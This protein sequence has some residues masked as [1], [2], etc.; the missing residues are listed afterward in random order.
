MRFLLAQHVAK[1]SWTLFYSLSLPF[2]M[3]ISPNNASCFFRAVPNFYPTSYSIATLP[4]FRQSLLLP[5][6]VYRHHS[7]DAI[8]NFDVRYDSASLRFFLAVFLSFF[9]FF[10][11]FLFFVFFRQYPKIKFTKHSLP[12]IK[13]SLRRERAE[14]CFSRGPRTLSPLFH[15]TRSLRP[16]SVLSLYSPCILLPLV[17]FSFTRTR[18]RHIYL[19]LSRL[20]TA[21]HTFPRFRENFRR[22]LSRLHLSSPVQPPVHL[23]FAPVS[24]SLSLSRLVST[25]SAHT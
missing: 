6:P 16:G 18:T 21:P 8:K 23:S 10:F 20:E 22:S 24:L 17:R 2:L 15:F 5:S 11:F 1:T 12:L 14:H 3:N 7:R 13:C 4:L 25:T 19:S 9:L